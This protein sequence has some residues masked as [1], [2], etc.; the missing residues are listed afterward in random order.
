MELTKE[1]VLISIERLERDLRDAP[2]CKKCQN[3]L[4]LMKAKLKT[5][6]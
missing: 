4:A 6:K 2:G 3:A 1:Q 5:F